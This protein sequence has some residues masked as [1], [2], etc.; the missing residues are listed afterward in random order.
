VYTARTKIIFLVGQV[1]AY[2]FMSL[3]YCTVFYVSTR[4]Y[5][6]VMGGAEFF[7][8]LG[9]FYVCFLMFSVISLLLTLIPLGF[10]NT[11]TAF[12]MLSFSML[13][14]GVASVR[15]SHRFFESFG[16]LNPMRWANIIMLNGVFE[17]KFVVGA[18][19]F[20]FAFSFWV[21]YRFL[22]INPVWSRY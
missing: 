4:S 20:I 12:S 3:V 13:A 7:N 1:L 10:Q 14:L 6:G 5:Y 19:I 15:S 16:F 22:L 21:T 18:I 2:S 9:R 11:N 17:L 8:I